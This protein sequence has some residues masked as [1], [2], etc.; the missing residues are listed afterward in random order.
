MEIFNSFKENTQTIIFVNTKKFAETVYDSLNKKNYRCF[1]M[2]SNL[3]K[4]ERDDC[5]KQ[6]REGSINVI[7]AT[8][9]LS[10][11]FD[12]H[13]IKL[14]INFDVPSNQHLPDYESYL[15][16][17]GRSGRFGNSGVALTLFD[18]EEDEK[19]F[20]DIIEHYQMKNKVLPLS[21]GAKQLTEIIH[22]AKEDDIL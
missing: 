14:V 11:G 9:L 20:F 5:I 4:E 16:R 7:I 21:G 19:N 17:V 6:F 22:Q 18:R 10:R 13:T 3:T 8:N 15:H 2:F 12:M 1:I